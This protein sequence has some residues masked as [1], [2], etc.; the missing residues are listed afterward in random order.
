MTQGQAW[1]G[2]GGHSPSPYDEVRAAR[3]RAVGTRQALKAVARDQAA[4]VFVARD[5][6]P[7][8]TR[9]LVRL[10]EEKNVPIVYVDSMAE[11]GRACGIQVGAAAAA[12]L[13]DAEARPAGG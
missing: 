12:I 10:C 8:V 11:L 2:G 9:E 6:E 4:A 1:P 3:R 5:A 13:R 7:H